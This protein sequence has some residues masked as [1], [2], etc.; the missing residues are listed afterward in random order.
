MIGI[1]NDVRAGSQRRLRETAESCHVMYRS[2][3]ERN[4]CRGSCEHQY[5]C[6][7]DH[8]CPSPDSSAKQSNRLIVYRIV[9]PIKEALGWQHH[10]KVDIAQVV[11]E[12]DTFKD[13]L[14]RI[15]FQLSTSLLTTVRLGIAPCGSPRRVLKFLFARLI[16]MPTAFSLM[17]MMTAISR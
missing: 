16:L 3:V 14:E 6:R 7:G 9:K 15:V 11:R 13:L 10:L 8:H 4:C 5:G 12:I 1:G 2:S 17:P